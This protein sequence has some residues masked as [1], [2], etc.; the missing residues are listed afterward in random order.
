MFLPASIGN[1]SKTLN[2][3]ILMNNGLRSCFPKEIG[4]L[5]KLTVLDVNFNQLIGPLPN[6]IGGMRSLEQL[7]VAHNLLSGFSLNP[8]TR[9]P[10][11]ALIGD[12]GNSYWRLEGKQ[13]R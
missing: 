9:Q 4:L 10:L 6:E 1:M 5:K 7:D 13:G 2:E 8:A 12:G 3:I 11:T